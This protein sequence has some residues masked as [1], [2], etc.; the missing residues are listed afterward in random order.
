MPSVLGEGRLASGS[1]TA[2]ACVVGAG[3]MVGLP[4]V[5]TP[6]CTRIAAA[7]TEEV[8]ETERALGELEST[9]TSPGTWRMELPEIDSAPAA[10]G[11]RTRIDGLIEIAPVLVLLGRSLPSPEY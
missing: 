7:M 3:W 1:A 4:L 9:M 10:V 5:W 11:S 8:P 2:A 6:P